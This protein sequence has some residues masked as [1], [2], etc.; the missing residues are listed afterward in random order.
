MDI[1]SDEKGLFTP[2][3]YDLTT[4]KEVCRLETENEWFENGKGNCVLNLDLMG[5]SASDVVGLLDRAEIVAWGF[6]CGK[7]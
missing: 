1:W 4:G 6:G 2:V 3:L 7:V 5:K